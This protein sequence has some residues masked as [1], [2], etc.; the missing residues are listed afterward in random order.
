MS[1]PTKLRRVPADLDQAKGLGATYFVTRGGHAPAYVHV[2]PSPEGGVREWWLYVERLKDDSTKRVNTRFAAEY[3]PFAGVSR[4]VALAHV[5]AALA[6]H[7]Y[8]IEELP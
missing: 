4:A 2:H 3:D 6:T 7:G 1:A 8:E 5:N